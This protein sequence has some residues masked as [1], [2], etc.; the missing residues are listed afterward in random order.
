L[1]AINRIS[2]FFTT[3]FSIRKLFPNKIHLRGKLIKYNTSR[4]LF[5]SSFIY[6]LPLELNRVFF[7]YPLS[8][9]FSA[10]V[11]RAKFPLISLAL[12]FRPQENTLYFF[13]HKIC[14]SANFV[15]P[16]HPNFA[17]FKTF[18]TFRTFKQLNIYDYD[19]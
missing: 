17:T 9:K 6:S 7:V 14:K 8:V 10:L 13:L 4:V 19:N 3:I 12:R 5:I 18:R 16:L 15:V 2:K 1:E 11:R